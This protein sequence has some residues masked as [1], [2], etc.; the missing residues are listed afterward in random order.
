MSLKMAKEH[1]SEQPEVKC[2]LARANTAE[3]WVTGKEQRI[4]T[5]SLWFSAKYRTQAEQWGAP[6][7]EAAVTMPDRSTHIS[8]VALNLTFFA[9]I[10]CD[11]RIGHHV[12]Y[13]VPEQQFYFYDPRLDCYAS[14]TE[15]KLKLL[16]SWQLIMC[17]QSMPATVEIQRLFM[18]LQTD[19]QLNKVI[20]RA[21]SMLA[22]DESFFEG[23][24]GRKR[25]LGQEIV[26]PTAEPPHKLFVHEAVV[27][28]PA[29]TLTL[30][31]A[32]QNFSRYC[33]SK[34]LK[35]IARKYFKGLLAEVLREEFGIGIRNDLRT[36]DG[37]WTKGWTGLT[38]RLN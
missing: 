24:N 33:Q 32:Y 5:P 31:D 17:A 2:R 30:P 27:E 29:K 13:Y 16:L 8:P 19:H 4:N 37:R 18:D 7:L 15:E 20:T 35:P 12:V 21:K 1:Q 28:D 22:A 14:T 26:D 9:S 36:E 6:F 34:G 10:F 25:R 3:C 11:K 38:C 23:S